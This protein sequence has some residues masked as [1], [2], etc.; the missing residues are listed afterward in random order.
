MGNFEQKLEV[1]GDL[2]G[3]RF[4]WWYLIFGLKFGSIH[5][6]MALLLVPKILR[7]RKSVQQHQGNHP[8]GDLKIVPFPFWMVAPTGFIGPISQ[9]NI[10]GLMDG[11]INIC[12]L[13]DG[14]NRKL[15]PNNISMYYVSRDEI[16]SL[17]DL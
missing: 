16:Y 9:W 10:I 12:N 4:F 2:E 1:V 17:Y 5:S 15:A 7:P 3:E 11:F 8:V 14:S 13:V 6:M